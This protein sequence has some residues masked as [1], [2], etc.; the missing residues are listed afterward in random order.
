MTKAFLSIP[1]AET[2]HVLELANRFTEM[3][4][5]V[6]LV[7]FSVGAIKL[8]QNIT[9]HKIP[10]VIN[11]R[12][13]SLASLMAQHL[14][15]RYLI[16]RII[17]H[18]NIDV[19][20]ERFFEDD[21]G[22]PRRIPEIMEVRW[23]ASE[24]M[25]LGNATEEEFL[26]TKERCVRKLRKAKKIISPKEQ[27]V[28]FY[29]SAGIE[30]DRFVILPIA[31]NVDKLRPLDQ[32]DSR[33]KL[34]LDNSPIVM[35]VGAFR[36][37]QGIEYA[38]K[39]LPNVVSVLPNTKLVLVGDAG[40]YQGAK[41]RP[42]IDELKLLAREVGVE[43]NVIFTGTVPAEMVPL[44][45]NAADVCINLKIPLQ[46][47]YSSL[48]IYEYMACAKAVVASRAKYSDFL[49]EINAGILVDIEK[50]DEVTNGLLTLLLD[51]PLATTL[52]ENGRK[53]VVNHVDVKAIA[54]KIE[55]VMYEALGC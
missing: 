32:A 55:K 28:E 7:A 24:H 20:Y 1:S 21:L 27:I 30:Q 44:Y 19:I 47:D 23:M 38:I 42:T 2:T 43:G 10:P 33:D 46:V 40:E 6:H 36:K 54:K 9:F 37:Y 12:L 52:G 34:G 17:R 25:L 16:K 8:H 11:K 3:G 51:K 14:Y 26:K 15:L 50:T 5:N 31:I 4:H 39:A 18:Y 41:F 13:L 53:Y 22:Y 29:T 48:K 45:L 35:F 49:E